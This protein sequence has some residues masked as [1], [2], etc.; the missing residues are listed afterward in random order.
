[1]R[2]LVQ[3]KCNVSQCQ[4]ALTQKRALGS[5]LEHALEARELGL[6][7]RLGELEHAQHV[8]A[9]VSERDVSDAATRGGVMSIGADTKSEHGGSSL[10]SH[11]RLV[12]LDCGSAS[13]SLSTP[14]MSLPLLVRSL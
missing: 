1:M 10:C 13:A 9:V 4:G 6:R 7:K 14:D 5:S 11:L 12:S 3:A 8:R 2:K